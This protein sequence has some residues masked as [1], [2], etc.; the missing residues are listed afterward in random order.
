MPF[1]DVQ[2]SMG[3]DPHFQWD[4]VFQ[5]N[6]FELWSQ[7]ARALPIICSSSIDREPHNPNTL[8]WLHDWIC[9]ALLASLSPERLSKISDP[10]PKS[11]Q[12]LA[13]PLRFSHVLPGQLRS[14]EVLQGY[15]DPLLFQE[16]SGCLGRA[17][18]ISRIVRNNHNLEQIELSGED[19]QERQPSNPAI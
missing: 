19:N 12:I 7:S 15:Q 18:V 13:G 11:P 17:L 14:S 2:C 10:L 9:T 4:D 5:M 1:Q 3:Y 16:T 6:A 8:S